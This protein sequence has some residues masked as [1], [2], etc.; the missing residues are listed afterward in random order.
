MV[1]IVEES[2]GYVVRSE[3]YQDSF[4]CKANAVLAARILATAE[5][6]MGQRD[7]GVLVP[8]GNGEVVCM[9]VPATA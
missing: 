3:R 5:A 4:R 9:G 8:M 7:V 2:W 1:E 6:V